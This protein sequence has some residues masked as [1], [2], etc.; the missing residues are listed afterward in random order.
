MNDLKVLMYESL[1]FAIAIDDELLDFDALVG[2]D[3]C[4]QETATWVSVHVSAC[5]SR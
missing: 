3:L 4:T 1:I 2:I 5:H